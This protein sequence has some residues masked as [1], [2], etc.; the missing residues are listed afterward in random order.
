MSKVIGI[1]RMLLIASAAVVGLLWC[2]GKASSSG[3]SGILTDSRDGQ[4]YKTV[5]IGNQVWMAENLRFKID[6]SW[7][8]ENS[9]EN[10]GKYGRLYDWNTAKTICPA[11][12]HLPSR[13]EW[14]VLGTSAG[15]VSA[16]K[17]L[18]STY[19]WADYKG[20]QGNGTDVFGFSALPGGFRDAV[21]GFYDGVNGGAW[22][23]ASDGYS[24]GAYSWCMLYGRDYVAERD[25]IHKGWGLSVR[26]VADNP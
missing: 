22:W 19:G 8:Y 3:K 14:V 9:E 16:G 12:W 20:S 6:D 7:C 4:T 25:D 18:K 17:A 23:T 24:G 1:G 21:G 15:K 2:G 26:C 13:E 10:C 11:G 5:K